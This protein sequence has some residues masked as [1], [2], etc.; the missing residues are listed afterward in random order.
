MSGVLHI[1]DTFASLAGTSRP[2]RDTDF[3]GPSARAAAITPSD[4]VAIPDGITR[5]I[6]VG[7]AGNVVALINGVA[8]T[9]T[10][11]PVGTVLPIQATRVNA[12]GTTATA[13]VALF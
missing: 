7:G 13:L 3:G 4:T 10:A 12:T 1:L 2:A 5:G 9:F 8:I 11:V 6:Y